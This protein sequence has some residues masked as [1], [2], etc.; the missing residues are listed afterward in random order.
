MHY[1]SILGDRVHG[2]TVRTRQIFEARRVPYVCRSRS[3]RAHVSHVSHVSHDPR[4]P[5]EQAAG[6]RGRSRRRRRGVLLIEVGPR[7]DRCMLVPVGQVLSQV[8][9]IGDRLTLI[10]CESPIVLVTFRSNLR[11]RVRR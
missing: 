6:G 8:L 5:R 7:T 9:P 2:H 11:I 4:E 1:L 3:R 10:P